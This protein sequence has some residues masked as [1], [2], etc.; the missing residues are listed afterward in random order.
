MVGQKENTI[1]LC[2]NTQGVEKGIVLLSLWSLP[3]MFL[4]AR[5]LGKCTAR[6]PS[7][8]FSP[9]RA[10]GRFHHLY[11]ALLCTS[12]LLSLSA[13]GIIVWA[14]HTDVM[15]GVVKFCTPL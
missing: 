15:W 10:Q 9:C 4:S 8:P 3:L 12:L 1:S 5:G 7:K 6:S 2:R 11:K 14:P 13:G